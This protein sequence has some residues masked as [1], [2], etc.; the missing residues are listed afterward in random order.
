MDFYVLPQALYRY[1]GVRQILSYG[2]NCI[3]HK[4]LYH[5]IVDAESLIVSHSIVYVINGK[6]RVNTFDGKEIVIENGEMLFM[7]RDSYTISDYLRDGRDVEVYL[8][9]FNHDIALKFLASQKNKSVANST[10]C[11]L[12]PTKNIT[13]FLENIHHMQF[14]SPHDKQL[15][16]LKLLEFLHLVSQENRDAFIATLHTSESNK[17]KRDIVAIMNEHFDKNLRVSDFASLSGRS[18]STFNRAFKQRVG[19]TPKQ[20]LIKKKMDKAQKLLFGGLTVTEVAFE[21]GYSNVSHFIKAYKL[22]YNQ[23]PKEMQ[24]STK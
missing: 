15:L 5:D 1:E 10:I 11:K 24:K 2:D 7:P 19:K 23:T 6:V 21:V 9:F 16:E 18:L 8:L 3:V 12:Y 13:L 14:D 20:W 17:Q 22:V 4:K